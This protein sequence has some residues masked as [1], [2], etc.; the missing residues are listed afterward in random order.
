MSIEDGY[1]DNCLNRLIKVNKLCFEDFK[2]KNEDLSNTIQSKLDTNKEFCRK[3]DELVLR[4]IKFDWPEQPVSP[5]LR[6]QN[7]Q[8]MIYKVVFNPN[9]INLKILS[10]VGCQSGNI[11]VKQEL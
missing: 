5:E 11:I 10:F 2:F 6:E 8:S 9:W 3:I 7:V 1:F 4:D